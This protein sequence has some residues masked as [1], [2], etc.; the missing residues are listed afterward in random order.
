MSDKEYLQL[1]CRN[2]KKANKRCI[3]DE[4]YIG[5]CAEN[6]KEELLEMRRKKND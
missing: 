1:I 6:D 4:P 5:W 2:C 3:K